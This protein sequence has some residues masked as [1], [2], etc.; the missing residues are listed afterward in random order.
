MDEIK[1]SLKGAA[2]PN[3][4]KYKTTTLKITNLKGFVKLSR[5]ITYGHY[6]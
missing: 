2:T 5:R 6:N 3:E 4:G 1:K